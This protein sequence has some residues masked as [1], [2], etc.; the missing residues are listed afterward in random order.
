MI[1]MMSSNS[2]LRPA[3]Y[4]HFIYARITALP[5]RSLISGT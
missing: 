2:E 3:L 1:K 5:S 4:A